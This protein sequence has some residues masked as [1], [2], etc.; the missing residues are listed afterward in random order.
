MYSGPSAAVEPI[1]QAV[2][3][4]IHSPAMSPSAQPAPQWLSESD[5]CQNESRGPSFIPAACM[6]ICLRDI[7]RPRPK[8]AQRAIGPM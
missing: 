2:A 4:T 7:R 8:Y 3:Q 1:I 5:T 6:C